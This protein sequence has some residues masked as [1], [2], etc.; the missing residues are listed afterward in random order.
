MAGGGPPP[1]PKPPPPPPLHTSKSL[2]D[3]IGD[4]GKLQ[5]AAGA[6]SDLATALDAASGGVRSDA[7]TL[8]A[9]WRGG[10]ADAFHSWAGTLAGQLSSAAGECRAMAGHLE[11]MAS[12]LADKNAKIHHLYEAMAAAAV[13]G[14]GFSIITFG[15]SDAAAAGVGAGLAAEA[16]VEVAEAGTFLSSAA[17]VLGELGANFTT[18]LGL[19]AKGLA[20]SAAAT[21]AVK[22][23]VHGTPLS[24]SIDD[25]TAVVD[26]AT[27]FAAV[28]GGFMAEHPFLGGAAA[29]GGAQALTSGLTAKDPLSATSIEETLA[30]ALAGGTLN[31]AWTAAHGAIFAEP[32]QDPVEAPGTAGDLGLPTLSIPGEGDVAA[33]LGVVEAPAPGVLAPATTEPGFS[34]HNGLLLPDGPAGMEQTPGGFYHPPGVPVAPGTEPLYVYRFP[35][36]RGPIG[37]QVAASLGAVARGAAPPEGV[38]VVEVGT[39]P[40]HDVQLEIPGVG[41]VTLDPGRAARAGSAPEAIPSQIGQPAGVG[42]LIEVIWPAKEGDL[43]DLPPVVIEVAPPPPPGH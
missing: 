5:A 13:V 29:A 4:P 3:P 9:A 25:V 12:Y 37:S 22:V 31:T 32:A 8:V 30:A 6:W 17:G 7:A 20:F 10:A 39:P 40:A 24:W 27:G 43:G 18:Y 33:T 35:V 28:P 36:A 34:W 21:E 42:S 1:P 26:G 19:W 38:T 2:W 16:G 15:F 11:G 14:I 23:V 41:Q